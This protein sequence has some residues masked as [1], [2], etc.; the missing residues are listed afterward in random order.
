MK[1]VGH[2]IPMI[3]H[4][5]NTPC[6]TLLRQMALATRQLNAPAESG[7]GV[8]ILNNRCPWVMIVLYYLT[9]KEVEYLKM[10]QL[11]PGVAIDIDRS[12]SIT[13][14]EME[15]FLNELSMITAA[16][17]KKDRWLNFSHKIRHK[18]KEMK[19][20]FQSKKNADRFKL[21][22]IRRK[23]EFRFTDGQI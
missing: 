22:D 16:S 7:R 17:E 10:T 19:P 23:Y 20:R 4:K 12:G 11:K 1:G 6:V 13:S 14:E 3:C 15:S 18:G 21:S 9:F 2:R 5:D 8:K